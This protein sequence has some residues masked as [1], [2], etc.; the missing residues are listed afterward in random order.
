MSEP[1]GPSTTHPG[2]DNK[3]LSEMQRMVSGLPYDPANPELWAARVRCRRL[4]RRYNHEID[5]DD[6]RARQLLLTE[7]LGAIDPADPPFIEPPFNCDY[8]VN[9]V[10]GKGFYCNFGCIVLDCGPITIGDRVLFG[11]NVQIYA[12]GHELDPVARNGARGPETTRPVVIEDDVWVGGSAVILRGITIGKGSVIA[13]GAV[14]TADVPANSIVAG[15]PARVLR[16]VSPS[17]HALL[18][19]EIGGVPATG[20]GET[21]SERLMPALEAEPGRQESWEIVP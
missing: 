8:G 14:V 16:E 10:L 20:T 17:K 18:A 4:L 1:A 11:P 19:T 13:A 15:N 6:A 5:Y 2:A 3:I 7:L 12:V 9:I 21:T